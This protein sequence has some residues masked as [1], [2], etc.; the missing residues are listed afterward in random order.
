MKV[1][2]LTF[3]R[4]TNA[5]SFYRVYQYVEP[6]R[7][8]GISLQCAEAR[9]FSNWRSLAEFDLVLLQKQ[10]LGWRKFSQLEKNSRQLAYDLDDAIWLPQKGRHHFLTQ[11]RLWIRIRKQLATV[12]LC[13]AANQVLAGH[14]RRLGARRVEVLPMALPAANWPKPVPRSDGAKVVLGW[15][16]APPN[17]A[18]LERLEPALREV[19]A[20]HPNAELH[21]YCGKKPA[22][23]NLPFR[24]FPFQPGTEAE[25]IRGFDIG[26]L[27]LPDDP[28][29]SAKSPIKALQ[30]FACGVPAVATP[31]GATKELVQSGVTGRWAESEEEWVKGLSE[32]VE[33]AEL[34]WKLGSNARRFFE[35]R[36]A[37]ESVAPRFAEI[38]RG[39]VLERET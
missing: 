25:V 16:G 22:F 27:P 21:V 23:T 12:Q 31:V 34:R 6:L 8:H 39:T 7:E 11:L 15:S 10:L 32:L 38:L 30:Y 13:I 19:L 17:L 36:H 5:S 28:F 37:L 14:T 20:R 33:R 35:E 2:A 18:Y 4:P 26:L 1:F 3:G 9:T 29:A 24:H